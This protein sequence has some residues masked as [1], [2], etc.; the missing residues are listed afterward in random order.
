[1]GIPRFEPK[2]IPILVEN[3]NLK[4]TVDLDEESIEVIALSMGNP[5]AVVLVDDI[6]TTSVEVTGLKIQRHKLFPES[7]NVSFLQIIDRQHVRLRVYERG[8]GRP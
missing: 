4:Y 8:A 7:V 1:M 6:E 5:H 3:R 2:A